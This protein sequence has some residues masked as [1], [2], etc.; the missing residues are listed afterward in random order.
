MTKQLLS[1]AVAIPILS[2]LLVGCTSARHTEMPTGPIPVGGF[3]QGWE[4]PLDLAHGNKVS[5][6]Y[7]VNDALYVY[8]DQNLVY[9][10]SPSGGHLLWIQQVG[11]P[12]DLLTPPV[13]TKEGIAIA[14]NSTIWIL[15]SRGDVIRKIDVG[16]SIRSPLAVLGD[17][18]YCGVDYPNGGRL[19]KIDL[20]AQIN[21]TRWELMTGKGL[22]ATPA[23]YEN[24]IFAGGEDGN[25]YA[26][27]ED[28]APLWPL[29]HSA[30]ATE[31][32]ILA[33]LKVD[34]FGVYVASLD[35]KLYCI[36]RDSGRLK[37]KFYAG[38]PL[39]KAPQVTADTVYQAISHVGLAAIDKNGADPIRSPR[40]IVKDAQRFLA[41]DSQYAYLRGPNNSIW[42]V[43]K[44]NGQI[45]LRSTR[46]D[47]AVFVTDPHAK[48]IY[49]A[50]EDGLVINVNPVTTPGVVGQMV[51]S[52]DVFESV[53]S[54]R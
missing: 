51:R 44:T 26:V 1:I 3:S 20:T 45:K 10:V 24:A 39:D 50:T 23:V 33:G 5:H 9:C 48:A 36:D 52:A 47:L 4:A 7:L 38:H 31:G 46:N 8:T 19:A 15:D 22:S 29:Y 14:L 18:V 40:W 43:D 35:S 32:P 13:Q 2:W 37:W 28:R 34:A 21:P 12:G 11:V 25:V 27:N 49:V 30:F 41:E 42:G 53:A 6:L 17:F 54:A 16:H